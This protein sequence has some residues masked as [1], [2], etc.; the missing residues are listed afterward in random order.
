[1]ST[2]TD[3]ARVVAANTKVPGVFNAQYDEYVRYNAAVVNVYSRAS[4]VGLFMTLNLGGE[5]VINDQ[6]I[7]SVKATSPIR[8]DDLMYSGGAMRGDRI[9]I[10]LR[11]NTG[12]GITSDI[13]VDIL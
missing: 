1:M 10:D 6:A 13:V 7:F 3:Q 11:N 12:A 5:V 9:V 8:P 2:M 4:A